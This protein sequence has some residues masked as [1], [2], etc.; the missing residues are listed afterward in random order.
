MRSSLIGSLVGVLRF[1]L[2]RKAARVR[3]FELGRVFL[4][5]AARAPTA[6]LSVA[7]VHQ[8]MRA[9]GLAYGP[10]D[11]AAVGPQAS[12]RVDFFDV[13][14][15]VEALLAPRQRALRRRRRIRRC[16]PGRCARVELDGARIG[17]RRRT[18]PALAPG[19]R[20]AAGA[21]AVRTRRWTRCWR[22]TLPAFA[23]GAAAAVGVAR[24]RA[25]GAPT[26]SRH[27]ALIG[28]LAQDADRAGA[29]GARCS[30][31]TSPAQAAAGIGA[32][33]RSLAR[34]PGTAATT[35]PH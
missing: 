28:A 31:S 15:D 20:A 8:P 1:N 11:A 23:A 17:C 12:A 21:G 25:R 26:T 29:L 18:A 5:D 32:G 3:V 22:A 7:G 24:H 6:T 35:K 4:R 10:A 2:A 13:K 27:D 30:T 16:I 9:G 34:A 19:L 14:G 33:E